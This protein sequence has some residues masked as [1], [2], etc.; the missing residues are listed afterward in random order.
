MVDSKDAKAKIHADESPVQ[1]HGK[2]WR[3]ST[4]SDHDWNRLAHNAITPMTHLF[5]KM[6]TILEDEEDNELFSRIQR[7]GT[8]TTVLNLSSNQRPSN[9]LFLL[10]NNLTLGHLFR[11]PETGKLKEHSVFV[12]DNSPSEA[13][14]SP[15]VRM[16]L[17]RLARLLQLKSVKSLAEYHS[18]RNPVE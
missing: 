18:K 2:M 14:A 16:W 13:P 4:L 12:V 10:L 9:K 7:T 17:V 1:K 3:I 6:E 8:A 11:N 5:L 15:L